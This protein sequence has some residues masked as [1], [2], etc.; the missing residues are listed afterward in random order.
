[1]II[2]DVLQESKEGQLGSLG[3]QSLG[4]LRSWTGRLLPTSIHWFLFTP[5]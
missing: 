4:P 1:M 3:S 2:E 5:V